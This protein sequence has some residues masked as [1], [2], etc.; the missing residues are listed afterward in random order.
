VQPSKEETMKNHKGIHRRVRRV[1]GAQASCYGVNT[2]D[3]LQRYLV[4]YVRADGFH[5]HRS[6]EPLIEVLLREDRI[7]DTQGKCPKGKKL[8]EQRNKNVKI[9]TY[10]RR[11]SY[12]FFLRFETS[13]YSL[14]F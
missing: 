4:N 3:S 8:E 5:R 2:C 10:I 11:D 14:Y 1:E 12:L 13:T 7:W 6:L 9:L